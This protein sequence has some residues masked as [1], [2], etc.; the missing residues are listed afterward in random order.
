VHLA[1][2]SIPGRCNSFFLPFLLTFLFLFAQ[3]EMLSAIVNSRILH[4]YSQHGCTLMFQMH[5][6]ADERLAS[7]GFT[8]SCLPCDAPVAGAWP[9]LFIDVAQD[10]TSSK[11][12]ILKMN[13][14]SPPRSTAGKLTRQNYP[15]REWTTADL[16]RQC[17]S[18]DFEDFK[19][20]LDIESHNHGCPMCSFFFDCADLHDKSGHLF[21]AKVPGVHG[22]H[23]LCAFQVAFIINN[24]EVRCVYVSTLA[25]TSSRAPLQPLRRI[26]PSSINYALIKQWITWCQNTHSTSCGLRNREVEE[27][28]ANLSSFKVIDCGLKK[29]ISAPIRCEYVALSYVWGPETSHSVSNHRSPSPKFTACHGAS[30]PEPLP[31]TIADGIQV[32]LALGL[33]YL[34]VDKYCIN[35]FDSEELHTQISAMDIICE[36]ASFTIIAGEGTATSGLPGVTEVPKLPQPSISINGTTWLSGLHGWELLRESAWASRAWYEFPYNAHKS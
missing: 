34:W 12:S 7:L 10:R 26:L 27:R 36:S 30:L 24:Q 31:K 14:T 35:Q 16:C 32:V 21:I 13:S 5:A 17:A 20:E 29:V 19:R 15:N 6:L 33:K 9:I 11:A 2:G 28:L 22:N 1:P 4:E 3:P 23:S 25:G 8:S 18:I